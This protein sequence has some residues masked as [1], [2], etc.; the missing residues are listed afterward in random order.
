MPNVF[1]T[2]APKHL[3]FNSEFPSRNLARSPPFKKKKKIFNPAVSDIY[4]P[5]ENRL[6]A[7]K[8]VG[9]LLFPAFSLLGID[10]LNLLSYPLIPSLPNTPFFLFILPTASCY[11]MCVYIVFGSVEAEG[12]S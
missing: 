5:I 10:S 6:Q 12:L 2:E 11:Y 8:Y 4:F 3:K 7:P 1:K 9:L